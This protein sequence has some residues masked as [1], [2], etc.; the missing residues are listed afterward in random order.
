MIKVIGIV[1]GIVV[2]ISLILFFWE[3]YHAPTITEE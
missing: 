3:I 1:V 2:I